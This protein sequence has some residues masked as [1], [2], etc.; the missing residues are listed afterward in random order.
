MSLSA[1]SR[2]PRIEKVLVTGGGGYV[3]S[4]L[5]EYLLDQGYKVRVLDL[6]LYGEEPL[7]VYRENP[8][9]ELIVGDIRDSKVVRR[10]VADVDAIIHLAAVVGAPES[11]RIPEITRQI[12]YD[13]TVSLVN[14]AREAR[15]P[16]FI[17]ASTCSNYGASN[18]QDLVDETSELQPAS[19]Y[20]ETKV[21]AEEYIL[22]QTSE[23]F[24]P[25]VCRLATVFG[26]SPRMRFDLLLNKFVRDAYHK[27]RLEVLGHTWR[28]YIHVVDTAR[29]FIL[30]LKSP[31]EHVSGQIFNIGS[32]ESNYKKLDLANLVAKKVLG[33]SVVMVKGKDDPRDYRVS[34]EKIKKAL[35][36]EIAVPVSNGI[37]EILNYLKD[38]SLD[39]YNSKYSN[40]H[41]YISLQEAA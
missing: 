3:G 39:P 18:T 28:T 1:E 22:G 40:L 31:I 2:S 21:L 34:F 23:N 12:N 6:L 11:L 38:P 41:K 25:T 13:A 17:F 20:A 9:F 27:R 19:P 29:A 7:R 24:H 32:E 8:R 14:L 4:V 10:S 30:L 33:T 37:D 35:G 16:R 5:I 36:C 26:V 15:V